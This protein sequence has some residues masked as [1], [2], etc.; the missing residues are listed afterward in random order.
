LLEAELHQMASG[1]IKLE[2]IAERLAVVEKDVAE[3]KRSLE[4]EHQ[5]GKPWYLKHAG[6]FK[7]DPDF[8]EIVRLGRKIRRADRPE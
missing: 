4:R 8:Q 6:K 5:D 2:L 7:G 3:L 1:R